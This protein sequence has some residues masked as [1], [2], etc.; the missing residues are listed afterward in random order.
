MTG[1]VNFSFSI[2]SIAN[3]NKKGHSF[4]GL[5]F[6]TCVQSVGSFIICSFRLMTLFSNQ[7]SI[8][9]SSSWLKKQDT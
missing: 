5:I 9:A 3:Q 8:G 2:L 1:I 6:T 4:V 7:F